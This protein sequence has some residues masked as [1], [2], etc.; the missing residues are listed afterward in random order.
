[1]AWL[2]YHKEKWK[3]QKR[4]R[5]M[6]KKM[7]A[8]QDGL[9][10]DY[11]SSRGGGGGAVGGALTGFLRQQNRALVDLHWQIIQARLLHWN[12]RIMYTLGT[13]LLRGLECLLLEMDTLGTPLLRGLE[14][15]LLEVPL[16]VSNLNTQHYFIFLFP[17]G[18]L[19]PRLL[20]T[21]LCGCWWERVCIIYVCMSLASSM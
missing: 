3:I 14:C 19:S 12:L 6:Q 13:P 15:L 7:L 9:G 16:N 4:E 21:S 20:A 8:Q 10:G 11:Y 1:M 18:R 17:L 2:K 5:D